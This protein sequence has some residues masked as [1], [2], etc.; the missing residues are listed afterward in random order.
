ML[1][2]DKGVGPDAFIGADLDTEWLRERIWEYTEPHLGA[3]VVEHYANGVRLLF[4]LV[5][6]GFRLHRSAKKFKHRIG[7]SCVEMSAEEQRRAEEDRTGYDWSAELS[8]HT[9]ADTS[10]AAVELVRRY[11]R[12]TGGSSRVE[13]ADRPTPDLLRRLGVLAPGDQ[14]TK[15][16]S[17]LFVPG[18]R[19]LIDYK[20]RRVP[21]GPSVD[22][23]EET[24]PLIEAYTQVKRRIDAVNE[25]RELQ[26]PSGVHP[27]IK[28]VPDRAVREALVNAIIHRDYRQAEAVDV[29][30]V[31]TE[32]V[33]ASPGGFPPG[34]TEANIISERSHP[35]NLALA[36]VFRSLRLAEQEGVGVDRMFR[37][38]VSV[39]HAVPTI[40]DRGGRVRCVLVGGEPS[41]PVVALISSLPQDAQDDVDLT[42]ILHVLLERANVAAAELTGLLQKLEPECRAALRRGE[43]VGVLQQVSWTTRALPRWRLSDAARRQLRGVL[44][45]I[46][47]S[48]SDT[49]EFVIRHLQRHDSIKPKDVAD[50]LDVTEDRGGRILRELREAEVLAFGSAQERGRGVFHVPGP[51]FGDALRRHGLA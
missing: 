10:A 40:A 28:L 48:A 36:S 12:E 33:V 11:L 37:D 8:E 42:L 23:Q 18:D 7:S 41:E 29:E 2:A 47:S 39:G 49:E 43:G 31:G 16:G 26:L 5:P 30:F 34:I 19:V 46:N 17:L 14:L 27:R 32:L 1:I 13:L 6:R 9:L 45:Y 22:R 38:M 35:R 51:R 25:E 15:A 21:G 24:A 20:R 44:P 50:I 3:E 4:V